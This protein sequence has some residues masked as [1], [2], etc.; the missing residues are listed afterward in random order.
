MYILRFSKEGGMKLTKIL[1]LLVFFTLAAGTAQ[2]YA[3]RDFDD[4][5]YPGGEDNI[6]LCPWCVNDNGYINWNQ[7]INSFQDYRERYKIEFEKKSPKLEE[8]VTMDQA[9]YLVTNYIYLLGIPNLMPGKIIEK[10]NEFDAEI[11]TKDGSS[12]DMLIIDK[13]TGEI[14]SPY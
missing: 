2:I 12:L 6:W 5:H 8:P 3:H 10:D 1:V 11:I 4:R 14:K 9:R 7:G 13:H